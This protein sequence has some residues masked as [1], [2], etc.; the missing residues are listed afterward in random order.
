MQQREFPR[1]DLIN[2]ATCLFAN[3]K[4]ERKGT[5]NSLQQFVEKR[6]FFNQNNE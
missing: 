3:I 4:T 1:N 2:V 6:R 5:M